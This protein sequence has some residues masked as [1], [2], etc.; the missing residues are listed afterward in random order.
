MVTVHP[1]PYQ[2]RNGGRC[3]FSRYRGLALLTV[4]LL[5]AGIFSP[6]AAP[7]AET[8]EWDGRPLPLAAIVLQVSAAHEDDFDWQGLARAAMGLTEGEMLTPDRLAEALAPLAAFGRT[9]QT[10]AVR[11]GQ[12]HLHVVLTPFGLIHTIAIRGNYP[13]F[14]RDVRNT[15][16][17]A[18]GDFFDPAA[19]PDQEALV[20]ERFRAEGYIDPQVTITWR[21]RPDDGHYDI[22]VV[23]EKGP[24]YTLE[25]VLLQGNRNVGD[26]ALRRRMASWRRSRLTLG[27]G[28]LKTPQFTQDLRRLTEYYRRKGFA[29]VVIEDRTA[30]DPD[31]PAVQGELAIV[32]GPRYEV[33]FSGNDFFSN[34]RLR[35]AL[36]LAETGNRGNIGLRRSTHEIRRRY[37]KAGFADV[38]VR[39]Q[40]AD[41]TVAGEAVRRITF[42]IEEGVRHI[43]TAVVIEGNQTLDEQTLRGQMLTRPP[44]W[45]RSGA[46]VAEVL[47]EDRVAIRALYHS[48]GFLDVQADTSAVVDP[49]SG[50]VTV[51]MTIAEGPRTLVG[52]IAIAAEDLSIP[53][54][55][56]RQELVLGPGD[57]YLPVRR[58]D[59]EERL[60]ARIAPLG[61]PHVN[62]RGETTL[63]EDR[64]RA[65]IRY[66]V[67]PGPLVKVGDL[68]FLGNFR[69]REKFLRREM[70][71]QPDAP[72]ALQQVWEAQRDLRDLNIFDSVQV[73]TIGLK[74]REETV[75]LLVQAA[76]QKPYY[77]EL[78]GGYQSDKGLY[79]RTRLGDRNFLGTAKELRAGAEISEVGYRW[80][81][82]ISEPRLLGSRI[83]A[84]AGVF[85]ERSEPFNQQ[86]GT[87]SLGA[88]VNFARG[89]G[90]HYT[91]ALALR[92]ERREQFLRGRSETTDQVDPDTLAPRGILMA[93]PS[94]QYDSRDSF[95]RPRFGHLAGFAVDISKGLDTTLDDFIKYRVDARTF[96]TPHPRLTLAGRVWFGLLEPYGG[97]AVPLDQLFF[98]GGT[99]SVRG[100]GENL[101]RFDN[102]GK[103]VG[104][105]MALAAGLEARIDIGRNFELV[106]FVDAGRLWQT[107]GDAGSDALRWSTG[108]GLQYIT[109]IGP[110]G[111][112]YGYKLDRQPNESTGALHLS[113]GYTF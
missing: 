22:D 12:A 17:I 111:L 34:R 77:V 110:I 13:L 84:D 5:L 99:N 104:G 63:S 71:L 53:P 102:E 88:G 105:R 92:Y 89:W 68:Y 11:D 2:G 87:Q 81:A 103:P 100:F 50:Q 97:D 82:A 45:I 49:D 91:T 32:E 75:H 46:Y 44:G 90:R 10:V 16:T 37:L 85:G 56:L 86:F 54:E 20:A 33:A 66:Q 74:E 4:V 101:L 18:G 57:P 23:I 36:V 41:E 96:Y 83:R 14:E 3:L 93:T 31:A 6:V 98:L 38:N 39:W 1:S 58:R 95:I 109:P 48:E 73:R 9:R 21:Q 64:T 108:L 27:R 26:G 60:A 40:T 61:H 29:D 8:T 24:H 30:I 35:K 80:E 94:V 28:R 79:G 69:T 7:A 15:M 106:P 55:Q 78:G 62:A 43:V 25:Q 72:F 112:F 51:T 59:D 42:I 113:I 65:D 67:D 52:D 107:P 76:E 19:M 70:G 47:E